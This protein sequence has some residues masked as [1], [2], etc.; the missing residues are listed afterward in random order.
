MGKTRYILISGG[1]S[2][3]PHLYTPAP[4]LRVMACTYRIWAGSRTNAGCAEIAE[5]AQRVLAC[6]HHVSCGGA[7]W[8]GC[9]V[10]GAETEDPEEPRW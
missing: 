2:V 1:K 7:H 5:G 6:W 10:M 3:L 9:W 4:H 8:I